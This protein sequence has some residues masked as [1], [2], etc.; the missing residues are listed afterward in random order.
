MSESRICNFYEYVIAE[1]VIVTNLLHPDFNVWKVLLH[2][3]PANKP[4]RRF[5]A[6]SLLFNARTGG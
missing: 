5:Q 2:P 3:H 4:K 1:Y 6:S